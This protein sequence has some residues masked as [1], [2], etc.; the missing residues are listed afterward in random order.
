[1]MTQTHLL[2]AATLFAKRGSVRRN[3]AV[4]AG[5]L[6]P[7][8]AIYVLFVWAVATGIPQETVWGEIYWQ[9]PWQTWTA[10]GNSVPLYLTGLL[11]SLALITPNDGRPRWQALPALFCLAALTHLAGDFPL[12]NDDAHQ[13][14]WPLSEWRFYS[15]VSYWDRDHFAGIVAPLETLLGLALCIVLFRRFE[16]LWVRFALGTCFLAYLAVPLFFILRI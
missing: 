15:P 7:D 5:A 11:I 14:L 9:E 2:V 13:H 8:A 3:S 4:I 10:A 12:H 16:A 6:I 1:M